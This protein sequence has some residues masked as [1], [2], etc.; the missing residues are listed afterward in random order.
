LLTL[1][2]RTASSCIAQKPLRFTE[3]QL[4]RCFLDRI[5]TSDRFI[6]NAEQCKGLV[7]QSPVVNGSTFS[8]LAIMLYLI[9]FILEINV[10]NKIKQVTTNT[11][12]ES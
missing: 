2:F 7:K 1:R 4:D 9:S 3:L 10:K 5:V 8:T 12:Q 6:A 11:I